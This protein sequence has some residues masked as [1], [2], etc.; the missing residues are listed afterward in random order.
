MAAAYWGDR[1]SC[2]YAPKAQFDQGSLVIFG[3]DAP[4]ES[5]NP[6]LGIHAAVTRRQVDGAP[7]PDGWHP[8]ERVSVG[9]ALAAYTVNPARAAGR[10]KSQGKLASGY[11]ADLIVLDTNPY[12]CPAAALPGIQ[13]L[14]TM[15][16]GKWVY[17]NF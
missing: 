6:W 1:T 3:S 11:C 9:Q 13:P 17:R 2:A 14:G 15:A 7:G 12:S 10:E 4:V 16:A 5:P 8:E